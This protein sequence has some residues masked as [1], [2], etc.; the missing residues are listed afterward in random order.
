MEK[1][2]L[3]ELLSFEGEREIRKPIT[4]KGFT[5]NVFYMNDFTQKLLT[6]EWK[7]LKDIEDKEYAEFKTT[8]VMLKHLT[9]FPKEAYEEETLRQ[10]LKKQSRF[11]LQIIVEVTSEVAEFTNMTNKINNSLKLVQ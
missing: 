4:D 9:D 5:V 2:L 1:K 8:Q 11:M 3:N 10:L 7:K 6:E